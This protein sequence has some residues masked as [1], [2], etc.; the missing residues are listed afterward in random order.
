MKRTKVIFLFFL[1]VSWKFVTQ[2]RCVKFKVFS[3][4]SLCTKKW[5]VSSSAG[6][7][8][9]ISGSEVHRA[10]HWN[11]DNSSM[12][13][14]HFEIIVCQKFFL[15]SLEGIETSTSCVELLSATG[16]CIRTRC[17]LTFFSFSSNTV[18]LYSQSYFWAFVIVWTLC[19]TA[20]LMERTNFNFLIFI[21]VR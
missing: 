5:F 21:F 2:F 10:I 6:F 16:T 17:L 13:F 8:L 4:A 1:L 18:I 3:F 19:G 11:S 20:V 7:E 14:C 15:S 12:K 9:A